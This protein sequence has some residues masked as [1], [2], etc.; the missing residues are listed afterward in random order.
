MCSQNSEQIWKIVQY[1]ISK[2]T[3]KWFTQTRN[4]KI[5]S[6]TPCNEFAHKYLPVQLFFHLSGV[7]PWIFQANLANTMAADA[8]APCVARASAAMVLSLWNQQVLIINKER[9]QSPA[10]AILK[11]TI[12]PSLSPCTTINPLLPTYCAISMLRNDYECKYISKFHEMNT[13]VQGI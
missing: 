1:I 11:G 10:G 13:A 7:E 4:V 5:C 9:F 12:W 6:T 3:N 2:D 8:L